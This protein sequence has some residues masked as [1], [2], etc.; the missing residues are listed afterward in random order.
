MIDRHI[1]NLK[2]FVSIPKKLI[3][4]DFSDC[5]SKNLNVKINLLRIMRSIVKLNVF[6]EGQ[7]KLD[8]NNYLTPKLINDRNDFLVYVIVKISNL[9]HLD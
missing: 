1:H 5:L 7:T 8:T 4:C 3:D 9:T 6:I 2:K